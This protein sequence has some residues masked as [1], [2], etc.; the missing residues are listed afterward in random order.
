MSKPGGRE[1]PSL[2]C[3][4]RSQ[5]GLEDWRADTPN[6]RK[7]ELSLAELREG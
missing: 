2:D 7:L 3:E 6:Q 1:T 5:S 4:R